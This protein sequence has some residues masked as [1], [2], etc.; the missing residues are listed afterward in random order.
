VG[1]Y[2]AERLSPALL[3][4]ARRLAY[5]SSRNEA[6][7]ALAGVRLPEQEEIAALCSS[8]DEAGWTSQY[9]PEVGKVT[10]RCRHVMG[11]VAY[12]VTAEGRGVRVHKPVHAPTL[13]D[14]ARRVLV[15]DAAGDPGAMVAALRDLSDAYVAATGSEVA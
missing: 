2:E 11:W 9:L 5:S 8:C 10:G 15:S 13:L 1:E 14:A 4:R 7:D 6:R 3:D 12:L